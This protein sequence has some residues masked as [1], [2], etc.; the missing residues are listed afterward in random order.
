MSDK[1]RIEKLKKINLML[2]QAL[3]HVLS[4]HSGQTFVSLQEDTDAKCL[5]E[6]QLAKTVVA[7][8]N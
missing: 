7:I 1:E 4:E 6:L 2:A 5:E 3:C 8:G